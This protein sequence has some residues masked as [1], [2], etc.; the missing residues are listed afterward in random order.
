MQETE[1]LRCLRSFTEELRYVFHGSPH[2][3]EIL[4]PRQAF[5]D[6]ERPELNQHAVYASCFHSI[7]LLYAVIHE[8]R[9]RWGWKWMPNQEPCELTVVA[10]ARIRGGPGYLYVLEAKEFSAHVHPLNLISYKPVVPVHTLEIP[11]TIL[12]DLQRAEELVIG[13]A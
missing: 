9:N 10:P 11:P 1:L 5:H 8:D 6:V 7:S 3:V 12:E 2:L 13:L 4:E